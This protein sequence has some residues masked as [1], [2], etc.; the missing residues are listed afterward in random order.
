MIELVM[1]YVC[2]YSVV[3][4]PNSMLL[5]E[6]TIDDVKVGENPDNHRIMY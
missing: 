5:T 4:L 2:M 6:T 3:M 1:V